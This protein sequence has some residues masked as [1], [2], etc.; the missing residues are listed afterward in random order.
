MK[1]L[2]LLSLPL[3]LFSCRPWRYDV[4]P[5]ITEDRNLA[6]FTALSVYGEPDIVFTLDTGIV[7]RVEAPEK[8][9]DDIHTSVSNGRLRVEQTGWRE[10]FNGKTKVYIAQTGFDDLY[11]S[12]SGKIS[13]AP[14]IMNNGTIKHYGSGDLDLTISSPKL[15]IQL[16]GSGDLTLQGQIPS[17]ELSTTGSGDINAEPVYAVKAIVN[18]TGSG[19]IRVRVS[20]TLQVNISGSGD[21]RYWG[22]PSVLN[23]NITGSGDLIHMN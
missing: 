17:L 19:D 9:Q 20:D 8:L 4:G 11:F 1:R 16:F 15:F 13:G 7:V 18:C 2:I 3:F 5:V 12:G 10:W 21:V 14:L 22:N 23:V 6:P